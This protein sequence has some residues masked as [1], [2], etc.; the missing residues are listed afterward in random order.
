MEEKNQSFEEAL[1]RLEEIA[2]QMENGETGLERSV[3]LYKEGV[4]L[5][6]F[7]AKKLTKAQ[8]EVLELK[9]TADG[10]FETAGFSAEDQ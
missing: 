6:A 1:A 5:S 2:E 4:E 7:C 9:Q 8:Q 10:V 3:E